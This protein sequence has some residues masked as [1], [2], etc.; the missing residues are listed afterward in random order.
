MSENRLAKLTEAIVQINMEEALELAARI[1]ADGIPALE[2]LNGALVPA[3]DRV[4]VLFRDG[5]YFLPDILMC[6]SIYNQIFAQIEPDLKQGDYK[7]RGRIM[8]G[9]IKGDTHDIGKNILSALL[10]GNGFEVIN[11]GMNV[12][13]EVFLQKAAETEPDVIGMSA[14][15]TTTMPEMKNTIDLFVK[16]GLRDR[17][18]FVI[19]GAPVTQEFADQIGADGYGAEAQSGVD[20]LKQLL[21]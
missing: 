1:I 17:Y 8:L 10:Q 16:S 20:L 11:L 21:S 2:I 6:V 12:P 15:L 9:T 18:K 14:L 19:G 5:E 4:G 3:L 7:S 13:P